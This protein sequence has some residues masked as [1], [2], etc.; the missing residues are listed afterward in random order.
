MASPREPDHRLGEAYGHAA[1][2]FQFAGGV[3]LF[4]GVGWLVDRWLGTLP[5]FTVAGALLGAVLSFLS[6][7]YRIRREDEARRDGE[8]RG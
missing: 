4:L 8:K 5:V 2:G 3:L 1:L 7:Y 6:V